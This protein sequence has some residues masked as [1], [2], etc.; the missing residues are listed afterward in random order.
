[1]NL[2]EAGEQGGPNHVNTVLK[3]EILQMLSTPKIV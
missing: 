3:Y 1:M 2:R